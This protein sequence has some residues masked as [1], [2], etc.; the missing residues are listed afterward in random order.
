MAQASGV[1]LIEPDN[2]VL[3][4]RAVYQID[5][6]DGE[7]IGAQQVGVNVVL[8]GPPTWRSFPDVIA[9]KLQ[10]GK[11]PRILKTI[12]L[13]PIGVQSGL[14]T[15]NFFGDPDYP[16]DLTKEDFFQRVIEMRS[17]IK[18]KMKLPE[19]KDHLLKFSAMEMGLKLLANSTWR[20]GRVH[21]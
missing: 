18:R 21:R 4:V 15:L 7:F 17:T 12:K 13:K 19:F 5:A 9:S 3:P 10:T 11:C 16:I 6:E 8:S 2:D 1:A 20:F 14:K